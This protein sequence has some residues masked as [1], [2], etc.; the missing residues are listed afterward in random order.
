[1]EKQPY[2]VINPD[3]STYLAF[4]FLIVSFSTDSF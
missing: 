1:M 2:S 4:R 3:S